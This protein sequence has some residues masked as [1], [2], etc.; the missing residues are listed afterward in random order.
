MPDKKLKFKIGL[1]VIT[2]LIIIAAIFLPEYLLKR[3]INS[4][5]DECQFLIEND[6]LVEI[7]KFFSKNYFDKS[8]RTAEDIK[9]K[10]EEEQRFIKKIKLNI[11]K[12]KFN[13]IQSSSVKLYIET[14][15]S[16]SAPNAQSFDGIARI[17]LIFS[18]DKDG[19]WKINYLDI[20]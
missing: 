9:L 3:K 8:K 15:V 4:I 17:E 10:I 2:S 1:A 12:K 6:R 18:K 7:L 20:N 5:I 11:I 19:N 14:I 16:F 13:E